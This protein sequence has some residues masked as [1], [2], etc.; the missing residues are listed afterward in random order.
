VGWRELAVV[1]CI[2]TIGFTMALFVS[3]AALG[4]GP[5]LSALK[6]GA[7]LSVSG[8][9]LAGLVAAALRTGRFAAHHV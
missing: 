4:P 7:L 9:V 6:M 3:T 1:G 2:S 5:A 8:A